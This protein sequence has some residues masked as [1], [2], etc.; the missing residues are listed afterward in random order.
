L[1][2]VRS[3]SAGGGHTCA[4]TNSGTVMRWGW[5]ANGQLGDGTTNNQL[6]P[7]AVP[8]LSSVSSVSAGQS[9]TCAVLGDGSV[10]CWGNNAFGQLG[11]DTT[12]QS[13]VPQP[14]CEPKRELCQH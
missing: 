6:A 14:A 11:D 10:Q 4:D 13:L 7:K 12:T 1:S 9:H 3:I 2:N 5:N 8:G